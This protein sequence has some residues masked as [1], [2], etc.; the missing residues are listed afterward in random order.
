MCPTRCG[1]DGLGIESQWGGIF[2]ARTDRPWDLSSLLYKTY[3]V[4]FPG[5]KRP[6]RGVALT[7]NP[8][9]VPRLKKE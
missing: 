6:G 1:L 9:L 7:A 2:L 5:V 4:S 3:R 8:F